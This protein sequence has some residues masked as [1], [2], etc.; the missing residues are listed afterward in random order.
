MKIFVNT[1]ILF[2]LVLSLAQPGFTGTW[3]DEFSNNTIKWDIVNIS[4][5]QHD[6][7]DGPAI[8]DIKDGELNGSMH[9]LFKKSMFLTG[10][11]TWRNYSVSCRAKFVGEEDKTAILGLILHARIA[12]NKRY[13]F[14]MSYTDQKAVIVAAAGKL[15][16]GGEPFKGWSEKEVEFD[17]NFDTWYLLTASILEND[18]LQFTLE[19]LD[20]G[21]NKAVF[22]MNPM[23]PIKEGGLTGL[24]VE[25]SSAVFDDIEISGN[26]IPDGDTFSVESR[27]KLTTTW[28]ELKRR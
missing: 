3:T 1:G 16:A 25:Q 27:N 26:N 22:S 21:N 20:D 14:L 6:P 19:N 24:L 23:E 18:Q 4:E 17:I 13:M 15:K 8:W 5:W 9:E 7:N 11:L 10:E 12:D 28:S 2:I